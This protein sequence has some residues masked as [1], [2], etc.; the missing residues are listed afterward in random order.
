MKKLGFLQNPVRTRS[1]PRPSTGL[2][3][4]RSGRTDLFSVV[5]KGLNEQD[6]PPFALP[7][8]RSLGVVGSE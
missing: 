8:R 2:R 3:T 5:S 6:Y 7:A 1:T 4:R